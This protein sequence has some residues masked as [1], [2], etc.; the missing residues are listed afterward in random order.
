[1]EHGDDPTAVAR[2]IVAA[3]TD[4]KPKAAIHRRFSG[5]TREHAAPVCPRVAFDRQIRKLNHLPA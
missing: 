1:M 5:A 2:S 4:P 3:A